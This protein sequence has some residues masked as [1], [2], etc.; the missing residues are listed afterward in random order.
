MRSWVAKT[1]PEPG[2]TP[3]A[4]PLAPSTLA[5][6][7]VLIRPIVEKIKAELPKQKLLRKAQDIGYSKERGIR[8]AAAEAEWN[9]VGGEAGFHSAL[10]KLEGELPKYTAE[11]IG[12]KLTQVERDAIDNFIHKAPV[13]GGQFYDAL[14]GVEA[15]HKVLR[16]EVLQPS[17][18]KLLYE[19][20]GKDIPEAILKQRPFWAKAKDALLEVTNL[21]RAFMST[22]DDSFGGRQGIFAAAGN[23]KEFANSFRASFKMLGSERAY[24]ALK[25]KIIADSDYGLARMGKLALS[26]IDTPFMAGREE[27]FRGANLAEKIPVVGHTIRSSDRAYTGMANSLRMNL[28]KK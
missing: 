2:A 15:I 17:E 18:I 9:K 27:A 8:A 7:P 20:L 6:L 1:A 4:R 16:G 3:P 13:F 5:D 24:K 11:D 25:E 23:P 12:G 26:D 21:P 19:A 22:L 10:R 14:N 28:F